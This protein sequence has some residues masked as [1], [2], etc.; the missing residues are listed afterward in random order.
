MTFEDLTYENAGVSIREQNRVNTEV[1]RRLKTLNMR[2]DGLFGGA[3]DLSPYTGEGRLYLTIAGASLI[4]YPLTETVLGT[5]TAIRAFNSPSRTSPV[6]HAKPIATLDYIAL[7]TMS[8]PKRDVV[9]DFVEGVALESLRRGVP[10]IGGESAE[11]KDTYQPGMMDAFVHVLRL[12]S[13]PSDDRFYNIHAK[14]FNLEKPLLVASTDGTGTKTKIV[15]N[16]EDIIFHGMNDVSVQGVKPLGFALYVA[17]NVPT[18]ELLRINAA[19]KDV[20]FRY[21]LKQF[22]TMLEQKKSTYLP[23]EV[24]IAATCFGVIDEK[25]IITGDRVA[26]GDCIIGINVD[27]AMTNGYTLIRK[28][29]QGMLEQRIIDSLDKPMKQLRGK[30]LRYEMS[31]PHRPMSDILFGDGYSEGVV[32]RYDIKGM[33]HITGGG[34]PDNIIRMVP[35]DYQAVVRQDVLPVPPLMSLMRE[36]GIK[37]DELHST[38]NMGVGFTLTV[39]PEHAD[40]VVSYINYNFSNAIPGVDRKA[41]V[42]GH[43][44]KR[45]VD[46]ARFRWA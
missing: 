8:E 41:A 7:E 12:T 16:P 31:K 39:A 3:V 29:A 11:M 4:Q 2:A 14:V 18:Q 1:I 33:A 5:E 45:A 9:P 27:C 43:V 13:V 37:N 10:V 35:K 25:D 17:G 22:P 24:D 26:P 46:E 44:E 20:A 38:F 6:A 42:I 21:H 36:Y 40:E 30:S 34:Q 23:N 15:R 19:V 32:S 28:F